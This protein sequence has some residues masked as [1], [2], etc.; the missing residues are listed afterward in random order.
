MTFICELTSIPTQVQII[1]TFVELINEATSRL[2]K[3]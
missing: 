2:H 1:L 3:P